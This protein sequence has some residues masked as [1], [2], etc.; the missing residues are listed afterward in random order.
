[1]RYTHIILLH[2]KI[3]YWPSIL[4]TKFQSSALRTKEIQMVLYVIRYLK[5]PE[6]AE[7]NLRYN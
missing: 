7:Y 6:L 1:M 2:V 4:L 3:N 5:K